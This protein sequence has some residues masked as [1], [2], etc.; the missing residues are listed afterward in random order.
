[1][2]ISSIRELEKIVDKI[3]KK[4]TIGDSILLYGEIGVGK[5]TFVR[6]L[7]NKYEN[8]KK[9]SKSE[10]L[11][12]TFNIVFEYE[13]K[14]FVIKHLVQS[15]F[16]DPIQIDSN[17][18]KKALIEQNKLNNCTSINLEY[19]YDNDLRYKLAWAVW[20]LTLTHD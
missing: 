10:V 8:E 14:E 12:P 6:L 11:S 17:E 18:L 13:I 1:M 16:W 9:I 4:L 2:K 5:T 7:I 20:N 19:L 3:K 15:P